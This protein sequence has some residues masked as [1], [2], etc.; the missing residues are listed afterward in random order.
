MGMTTRMH[1]FFLL[2]VSK[3]IVASA[4]DKI[5][6]VFSLVNCKTFNAAEFSF[7][8]KKNVHISMHKCS[9]IVDTMIR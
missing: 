6:V 7:D 4:V 8:G 1:I 5:Q 9:S 2:R 3:T